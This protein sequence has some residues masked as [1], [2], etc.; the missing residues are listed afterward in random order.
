MA[1]LLPIAPAQTTWKIVAR[2][3][4][5]TPQRV[6]W[7]FILFT[8]SSLATLITPWYIGKLVD[9][10]L[11]QE[12][13]TYPWQSLA[14]IAIS[15]VISA[16]LTRQWLYQSQIIGTRVHQDLGVQLV[17]SS[18]SLDAQTI[19]DAGSGDLVSR[20]TNDL[21]AIRD[22]ITSGIPELTAT[23]IRIFIFCGSIL[24][25][26]V[27]LGMVTIPM[28]CFLAISLRFFLPKIAQGML[29]IAGRSSELTTVMTENVRGAQTIRSLGVSQ[30]R[31]TI[32]D[33][34][35]DAFY[36]D[37][38]RLV[39]VRATFW[40]VNA[41]NNYLPLLLTMLWGYYCV[42]HG[43]ATW[44]EV[45]TA[46]IL[47]F[48]LRINV[49]IMTFW[50][51]RMREMTVS[52]GRIC[53]VIDLCSQQQHRRQ[54]NHQK[55]SETVPHTAT[56]HIEQM[57]YG[58]TPDNHVIHHIDL[59]IPERQ[60]L[61]LIGRS[62]SGK[63]TLA[64]LIAGS[65]T[66]SS[67]QIAVL[68][69]RVGDGRYPTTPAADGRPRLLIC[70][71]EAHLF[72]GTIAENL[73][74]V[75]T[76][77]SEAEMYH[78]LEAVGAS[79]I[80]HFNDG[81]HTRVGGEHSAD[82]AV[83]LSEQQIQHIALARIVLANPHAVILDESTTALELEQARQSLNAIFKDRTVIIISH[84]ARITSLAQRAVLLENGSIADIGETEEILRQA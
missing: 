6:S 3:I 59:D 70:T 54:Q 82:N 13:R 58:Y 56:V 55:Y 49:E 45:S 64:R 2:S 44:G 25:L 30:H 37:T 50:I 38:Y 81:L 27:P 77:A 61:A 74:M 67:G 62:G 42:Q 51:T 39:Q 78:A 71:Q 4:F 35:I 40:A 84:D 21:E 41:F 22:I 68:G 69:E 57:S 48:S 17:E 20:I 33:Q 53:G 36:D 52:M 9:A 43:W 83:T 5:A 76:Q 65:L 23:I 29:N 31:Q 15:V 18:M 34:R 12:L 1:K 79:W 24:V 7:I 66:A 47:M 14:Y 19:E 72:L 11:N 63:T 28:L 80:H 46:A 8:L 10:V 16:W 26:S 75:C 73:N 60:S 32:L